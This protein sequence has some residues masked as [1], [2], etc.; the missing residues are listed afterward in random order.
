[1][2]AVGFAYGSQLS[3]ARG[4]VSLGTYQGRARSLYSPAAPGCG[5]LGR[6]L[7]SGS[8]VRACWQA[9]GSRLPFLPFLP[10]HVPGMHACLR[11][12]LLF[13]CVRFAPVV[14]AHCIAR[15]SAAPSAPL[16]L[17]SR[18]PPLLAPL[19]PFSA[20]GASVT[21]QCLGLLLA[22]G[23]LAACR[24]GVLRGWVVP[25][26]P[27]A[28]SVGVGVADLSSR[29]SV[30]SRCSDSD[31]ARLRAPA[32]L[33]ACS[34]LQRR[35]RSS[36]SGGAAAPS[37][38]CGAAALS[39]LGG[40]AALLY[41]GGAAALMCERRSRSAL[42]CCRMRLSSTSMKWGKLPR[43]T[44]HVKAGGDTC[45]SHQAKRF[46]RILRYKK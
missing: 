14:A 46:K 6:P 24:Q 20:L 23:S 7:L 13:L 22:L 43:D 17:L 19:V 37:R 38:S 28:L 44:G 29:V 4:P 18:P 12:M 25:L 30:L 16:F 10:G 33:A 34:V 8:S 32:C 42:L 1:M 21:S 27:S 31:R 15:S 41:S 35:S 5:R 36:R 39:Y 40:A 2:S 3:P 26:S 45:A 11:D 9:D